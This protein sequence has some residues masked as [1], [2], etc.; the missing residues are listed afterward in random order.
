M[1]SPDIRGKRCKGLCYL[2]SGY[3]V[4]VDGKTP[5]LGHGSGTAPAA[6]PPSNASVLFPSKM[7][8]RVGTTSAKSGATNAVFSGRSP[9]T[10]HLGTL[11]SGAKIRPVLG[12][13]LPTSPCVPDGVFVEEEQQCVADGGATTRSLLPT[14]LFPL[15]FHM[16]NPFHSCSIPPR[17]SP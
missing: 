2:L 9:S 5:E 1:L 8:P 15:T 16:P 11:R 14:H 12:T 3:A 6:T 10:V 7:P 13:Y 4:F 17:A